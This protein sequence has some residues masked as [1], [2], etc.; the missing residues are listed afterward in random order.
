MRTPV[1]VLTG[2]LG[3]G[4]TTILAAMLARPEFASAAVVVNEFGEIALD[5]HLIETSDEDMVVLSTGCLCCA[6]RGDTARAIG[7]LLARRTAGQIAFDRIVIETT[8]MADP[9]PILQGLMLD[10]AL[11]ER[12]RL[13]RV[14]ATVDGLVGEATLTDRAE[15]RRQAAFAD[16]LVVTKADLAGDAAAARLAHSLRALNPTAPVAV[17]DRGRLDPAVLLPAL[18]EAPAP[19]WAAAIAEPEPHNHH[20][21]HD[22]HDAHGGVGSV[23][24]R[25]APPVRAAALPLF[26]E[27][28]A[29]TYGPALLRVKGLVAVAE[30]PERPAVI[31]GVRHV[32]HP[33]DW[34][35]AWPDGDRSTRLVLIGEGLAPGWADILLDML[36]EEA[37]LQAS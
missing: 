11:A 13:G 34:L 20:D 8:G 29:E 12:V 15:A 26:L 22:H 24:L 18:D 4:K 32:F 35:D 27:A 25:R 30:A 31:H 14:V 1:S 16:R 28:L 7:D 6:A 9:A 33:L 23:T 2:F 37:T 21:H 19:Q 5:H 3:S 36:D 17:A 10:P